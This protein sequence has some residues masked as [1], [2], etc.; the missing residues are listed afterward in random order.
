MNWGEVGGWALLILATM[1]ASRR[2]DERI[3][4]ENADAQSRMMDESPASRDPQ[5]VFL[6]PP[7]IAGHASW[8]NGVTTQ[9]DDH[10]V[11]FSLDTTEDRDDFL[12][13]HNV[14]SKSA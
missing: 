7:R 2:Y 9:A 8:W 14:G 10:E 4:R 5:D 1:W 11:P 3:M 12:R 6:S 13:R